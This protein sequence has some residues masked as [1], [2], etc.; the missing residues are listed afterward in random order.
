MICV[1]PR[2][3]SKDKDSHEAPDEWQRCLSGN[4]VPQSFALLL[5]KRFSP[6][7]LYLVCSLHIAGNQRNRAS[8]FPDQA[9]FVAQALGV[10]DWTQGQKVLRFV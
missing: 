3:P 7:L 1:L 9:H 4:I 8:L 6:L 10:N 5:C 2:P